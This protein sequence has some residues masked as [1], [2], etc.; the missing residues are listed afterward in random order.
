MPKVVEQPEYD[1]LLVVRDL[2]NEVL[3]LLGRYLT[4]HYT[5]AEFYNVVFKPGKALREALR[6]TGAYIEGELPPGWVK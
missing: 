2:A 4:A 3:H 1:D 6:K 5:R